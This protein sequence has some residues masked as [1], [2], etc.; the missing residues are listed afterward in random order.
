METAELECEKRDGQTKGQIRA[1]R[2]TGRVPAVMYGP[3]S[4]TTS[5]SLTASE[6][7]ERVATASR[8][9]LIKLKSQVP[10]LNSKHVIIKQI[11]RAALTGEILHAD[12]YEVNL[13]ERIRVSVPLKFSG[14]AKGVADGG[15]LQPLVRQIEVECLP[16]EIPESVEVDVSPLGI[17]DVIHVS[18]L[19]FGDNIK[20]IFDQDFGIVSVL[21]PT[22]EEAP[23]AAA[24]A[25]EGAP[26]EGAPVEGAPAGAG[27]AAPG[28]EGKEAAAAAPAA[29]GKKEGG[30]K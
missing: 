16:L 22:V 11:Q 26:V 25:V 21:P 8:Q 3:K 19:Q 1:L 4:P 13:E 24:A 10:E 7:K 15:I 2:R 12:L 30:K 29:P 20:P 18:A 27:A 6:L 14:R 28:A 17:H 9:R 23:V 5:I